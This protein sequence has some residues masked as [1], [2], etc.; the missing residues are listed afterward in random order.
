MPI[1]F[2]NLTVSHLNETRKWTLFFSILGFIF[3]GLCLIIVPIILITSKISNSSFP[4]WAT[5]LPLIF[6]S[7]IYFFPV[8]YLFKFSVHSKKA[9]DTSDSHCLEVSFKFLKL[10]YR[11]MGIFTIAIIILYIILGVVFVL[12]SAL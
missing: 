9:I 2:N 7:L 6:L 5:T 10:H 1:E 3:M 4:T 11:F 8:Y 12:R